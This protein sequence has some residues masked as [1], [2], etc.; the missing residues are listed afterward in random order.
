MGVGVG[1][2]IKIKSQIPGP[3]NETLWNEASRSVFKISRGPSCTRF[4][5][6]FDTS[7]APATEDPEALW[8]RKDRPGQGEAPRASLS[9]QQPRPS[10]APPPGSPAWQPWCRRWSCSSRARGR[11]ARSSA[12]SAGPPRAASTAEGRGERGPQPSAPAPRPRRPP[13]PH[14]RP[15]AVGDA[16]QHQG[17]ELLGAGQGDGNLVPGEVAHVVVV[18]ELEVGLPAQPLRGV[19]QQPARPGVAV[20]REDGAESPSTVC[21]LG[22]QTRSRPEPRATFPVAPRGSSRLPWAS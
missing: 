16:G 19:V 2:V 3:W 11:S 13:R 7:P 18:R 17:A 9:R 14:L 4:G 8:G 6:L 22:P 5:G 12:S 15:H 10:A 20:C 1:G 21:A